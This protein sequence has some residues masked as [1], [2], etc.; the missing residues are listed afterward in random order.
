MTV[1][2]P[3]TT[4]NCAGTVTGTTSDALTYNTQGTFTVHWTFSDGHGNTSTANQTVIV[5]D[6]TPPTANCPANITTNISPNA[7]SQAGMW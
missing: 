7:C 3:T 1:T 6:T 2:P 4:D 5:Q